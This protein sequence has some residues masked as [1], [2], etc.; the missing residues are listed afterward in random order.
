MRCLRFLIDFWYIPFLILGAAAGIAVVIALR[1][2]GK[3]ASDPFD[4]VRVELKAIDAKREARQ[5]KIDLGE[6]KAL[7]AVKEKYAE[8]REQL[9]EKTEARVKE[10]ENDPEKLAMAMERAAWR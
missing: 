5:A 10:L 1:Q 7:Q 2:A 6:E 3:E 4:K 9:D 8:R